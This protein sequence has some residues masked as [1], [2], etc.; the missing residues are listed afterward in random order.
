MSRAIHV[1]VSPAG[2]ISVEAFGFQG[3]GCEAA[4]KAIGQALGRST[5]RK[6][7][8]EHRQTGSIV[9]QQALGEGGTP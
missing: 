3:K 2:D 6:F 5:G 1:R 8:P 4:T 9:R 7:K